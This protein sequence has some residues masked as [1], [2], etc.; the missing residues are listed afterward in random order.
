MLLTNGMEYSDQLVIDKLGAEAGKKGLILKLKFKYR[1]EE[2]NNDLKWVVTSGL[3]LD[4]P[5]QWISVYSIYGAAQP[6]WMEVSCGVE[7]APNNIDNN[8][9]KLY[10]W[11]INK[12]RIFIDDIEVELIEENKE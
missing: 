8:K 11:N 6:S 5:Y 9:I 7:L 4:K 12:T 1:T 10:L 2:N 3:D